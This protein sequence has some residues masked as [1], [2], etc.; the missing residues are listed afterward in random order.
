MHLLVTWQITADSKFAVHILLACSNH[1]RLMIT[2]FFLD[3][4]RTL[5][6]EMR[7]LVQEFHKN[8]SS[9]WTNLTL[10]HK[11]ERRC[12]LKNCRSQARRKHEDRGSTANFGKQELHRVSPTDLN[13]DGWRARMSKKGRFLTN[14]IIWSSNLYNV[15]VFGTKI[16]TKTKFK[17]ANGELERSNHFTTNRN[18]FI[19]LLNMR[20]FTLTRI[21]VIRKKTTA[22]FEKYIVYAVCWMQSYC[23]FCSTL[24]H[25]ALIGKYSVLHTRGLDKNKKLQFA[26]YTIDFAYKSG[27]CIYA[28]K[29]NLK[30][31]F[32]KKKK[33]RR[34]LE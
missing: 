12:F 25:I 30:T 11:M 26:N 18:H 3:P 8:I 21:W 22:F 4:R 14:W 15:L 28:M 24:N 20:L 34:F 32:V 27:K 29:N 33:I 23:S 2:S 7:K 31:V 16:T 9:I 6:I 10:R 1:W 5:T 19:S 13:R 17:C